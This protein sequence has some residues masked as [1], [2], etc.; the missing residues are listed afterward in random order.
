MRGTLSSENNLYDANS[1]NA[2]G[3]A[4]LAP[5]QELFFGLSSVGDTFTNNTARDGGG[6]I[7]VDESQT[8]F[9]PFGNLA[10]GVLTLTNGL[11]T[12][13]Q[14]GE[15]SLSVSGRGGAIEFSATQATVENT[16]FIT[17][18]APESGDGQSQGG[19]IFAAATDAF[20]ISNSTISESSA[21]DGGAIYNEGVLSVVGSALIDNSV[22]DS[23]VEPRGGA[24]ASTG[25]LNVSN[26][27]ISGNV[28]NPGPANTGDGGAIASFAGGIANLNNVTLWG[29]TAPDGGALYAEPNQGQLS[30]S[31]T[32]FFANSATTADC[33]RVQS[34][35]YS[36]YDVNPCPTQAATDLIGD[37]LVGLLTNNGGPTET[38][39]LLP[40]SPAQDAGAPVPLLFPDFTNL[41][42][43]SVQGDAALDG[44]TLLLAGDQNI[45][46]VSSVYVTDPVDVSSN[47]S[48][49]FGF[50]ITPG[51][52]G[53]ASD[54]ITFTI[55]DDPTFLGDN[56]GAL[57]IGSFDDDGLPP[58]VPTGPTVSGVSVEFDTWD[59]GV[60]EGRSHLDI[61]LVFPG[62][63]CPR[64]Q[65]VIG[66]SFSADRL[67]RKSR[68]GTAPEPDV[69]LNQLPAVS[70]G[71]ISLISTR[72]VSFAMTSAFKSPP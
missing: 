41:A 64:I 2:R 31:S 20:T 60:A 65:R 5:E 54:G 49:R 68:P 51:S 52:G 62:Y 40:G 43:F 10:T 15:G 72:V 13:N 14:V 67:R 57:G 38:H 59:N 48:A 61:H 4:I 11:L 22:A 50:R 44:N 21:G 71:P 39:A 9:P 24:I 7:S 56:G 70:P 36:I 23:N 25:T 32:L 30:F 55:G 29:N 1:T 34:L 17:N 69:P 28:V 46:T 6:A 35:G 27:T 53:A 18:T 26:S 47:F 8:L 37:P 66:N 33:N 16:R 3:G 12:G 45:P 42:A 19:A 58:Y 63:G